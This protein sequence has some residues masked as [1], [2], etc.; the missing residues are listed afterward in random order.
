MPRVGL[1]LVTAGSRPAKLLGIEYVPTIRLEHMTEAQKRAYVIADNRLAE[2]AGWDRD[3]LALELQ[4][5]S[6]LD[7]E[8]DATITGFDTAEIDVLIQGIDL[9]GTGDQSDEVPEIDDSVP[10]V[11]R[12]GDLW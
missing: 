12:G 2:N 11:T 8:F 7:L 10:P 6:D 1:L 3:L 9:D 4:Y 5:L